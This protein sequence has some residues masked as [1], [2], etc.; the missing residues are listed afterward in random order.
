MARWQNCLLERDWAGRAMKAHVAR[1]LFV[2]LGYAG[3]L[4]GFLW[5]MLKVRVGA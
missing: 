2:V 5:L 1:S 3:L 4:A